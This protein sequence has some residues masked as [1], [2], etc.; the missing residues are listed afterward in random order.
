MK[1]NSKYAGKYAAPAAVRPE[2]ED[3]PIHTYGQQKTIMGRVCG[4]WYENV[5]KKDDSCQYVF[6]LWVPQSNHT[7]R[8]ELYVDA[9]QDRQAVRQLLDAP[10]Q[11]EISYCQRF[12]VY[13]GKTGAWT[14]RTFLFVDG[15]KNIRQLD[16][17]CA[18]A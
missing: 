18:T 9:Q 11:L 1:I 17:P 13:K 16:V 15:L 2:E 12:D 5:R 3:R 14:N 10:G 8:L 4:R 6:D 7:V